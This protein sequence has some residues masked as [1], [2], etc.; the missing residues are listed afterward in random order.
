MAAE[1]GLAPLPA[2]ALADALDAEVA[3]G[4]AW[5]AVALVSG[6]DRAHHV[7]CAGRMGPGGAP[8]MRPDTLFRIASMTKPVLAVAALALVEEG[9]LA[10]DAP[11]SRWLPELAEMRVLRHPDGPLTD[12]GPAARAITLDDLLTLRFGQGAIMAPPGSCPMQAAL[13]AAGLAPGPD[14]IRTP[15]DAW[16]AAL[17]ALPLRH[18]PGAA[19]AY[20]TGFDVLAVLL[21]RAG[22]AP[23]EEVLHRIVFGPL[24]M[25]DTG[26]H[27]PPD[28][29]DRLSSAARP[30]PGGTLALHDPGAGGAHAA[31]PAFPSELVSTAADYARFARM[32]LDHGAFPGGRVLSR[33]SVDA[34]LTDRITDA[35]K[36]RSPFFPGF[37]ETGG[38]GFGIG[39][40]KGGRH[41]WEGGFGTS[42][43]I[44]PEAGRLS[45]LLTQRM[46]TSPQDVAAF[47]RFHDLAL[48]R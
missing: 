43:R 24:G 40:G 44:H 12:T 37:W 7:F 48:N 28:R 35:Q 29:I 6:P 33:A 36:A 2:Q 8:P 10:L 41:G 11:V 17:G 25:A 16:M 45:I 27:A 32:L 15:P 42:F 21:A 38:W 19:W 26:F 9:V 34:M 14:P 20:H 3:G 31:P 47:E 23:L 46:M 13:E 18:Q 39:I 4:R 22:G 1:A 30:G 5:G